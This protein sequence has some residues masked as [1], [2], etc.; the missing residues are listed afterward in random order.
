MQLFA[1]KLLKTPKHDSL[2]VFM[3]KNVFLSSEFS[4]KEN[5]LSSS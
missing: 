2:R 5:G 1:E 4:L 3:E